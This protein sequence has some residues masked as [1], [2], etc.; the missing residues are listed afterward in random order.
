MVAAETANGVTIRRADQTG[1]TV[2]RPD[3][4]ELRGTGLSCMQEGLEKR[5]TYQEMADLLAYLSAAK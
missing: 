1:E 2:A 3:V 5:L 4:E